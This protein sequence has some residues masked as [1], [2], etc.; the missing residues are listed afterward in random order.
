MVSRAPYIPIGSLDSLDERGK[1]P[2]KY[3]QCWPNVNNESV[4]KAANNKRM[5]AVSYSYI[6][7]A[8]PLCMSGVHVQ[9]MQ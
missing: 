6:D 3:K 7:N 8:N 4:S 2:Y 1:D 9:F 5:K